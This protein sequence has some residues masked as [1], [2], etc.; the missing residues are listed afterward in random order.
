[1]NECTDG[2]HTCDQNADCENTDGSFTCNCQ[3]GYTGDGITCTGMLV[4]FEFFSE[5]RVLIFLEKTQYF[6]TSI[7]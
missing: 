6:P 1:M 3:S 2:T 7:T 4:T 5:S